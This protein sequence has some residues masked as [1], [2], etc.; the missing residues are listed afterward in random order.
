MYFKMRGRPQED[1]WGFK[2]VLRFLHVD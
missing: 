1:V 2:V